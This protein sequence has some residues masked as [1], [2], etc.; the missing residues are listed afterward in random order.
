LIFCGLE[1]FGG[2]LRVGKSDLNEIKEGPRLGEVDEA[3]FKDFKFDLDFIREKRRIFVG[4]E[5][6]FRWSRRR[7]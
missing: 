5:L 6:L 4:R 2:F 3:R 7:G 1:D